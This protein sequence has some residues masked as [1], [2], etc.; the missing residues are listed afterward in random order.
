MAL[1]TCEKASFAYEGRMILQDLNLEIQRGEY[2]CILGENGK[3]DPAKLKPITY[4]PVNHTY[5]QL[6]EKVGNAFKD[7]FQLK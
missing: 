1:I 7:G 3:I 6:G 4:D 5:L 2:L